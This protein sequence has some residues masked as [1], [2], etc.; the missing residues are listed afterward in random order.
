MGIASLGPGREAQTPPWSLCRGAL[1]SQAGGTANLPE[2]YDSNV[3]V[4]ASQLTLGEV[5]HFCIDLDGAPAVRRISAVEVAQRRVAKVCLR[6]A[7]I[8]VQPC[9]L[10]G[11]SRLLEHPLHSGCG[12][13]RPRQPEG[14]D[15]RA[16]A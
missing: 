5:Y 10:H 1:S 8:L 16:G 7:G 2:P 14:C 13:L 11:V 15:V 6:I 9:V 4:D 3:T 12:S